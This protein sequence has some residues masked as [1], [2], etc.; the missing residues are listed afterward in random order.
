MREGRGGTEEGKGACCS[1]SLWKGEKRIKRLF[2][3]D[4]DSTGETEKR[5]SQ[6]THPNTLER[7]WNRE[8]EITNQKRKNWVLV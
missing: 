1:S 7:E 8:R 4:K 2:L 6:G 3:S 5:E